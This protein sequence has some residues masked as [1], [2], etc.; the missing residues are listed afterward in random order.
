MSARR[1]ACPVRNA[2]TCSTVPLTY[3]EAPLGNAL[4]G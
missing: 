2:Q 3:T 4:V 1:G